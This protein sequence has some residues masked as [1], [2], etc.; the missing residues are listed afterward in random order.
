MICSTF[1]SRRR[2]SRMYS[3]TGLPATLSIGFGV[4]CVCGR[5][6]VPLPASGMITFMTR[7]SAV[8]GVSE[9]ECRCV[10]LGRAGALTSVAIL[11]ANDVVDLR[12]ADFENVAVGDRFHVMHGAGCDA[13]GLSGLELHVAHLAVHLHP[14]HET[15]GQ[16]V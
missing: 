9:S 1:P 2:S 12:R 5:K 8:S 14:V 4:M 16:E 13:E 15:A 3:I 6:R 11:E 7:A 10:A